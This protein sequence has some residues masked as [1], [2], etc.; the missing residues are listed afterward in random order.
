[1]RTS[2][3]S[4]I[5]CSLLLL[6]LLAG[7]AVNPVTGKRELSLFQ[8][9]DA[10]EVE[11]GKKSFPSA[12]QQMGGAYPEARL[13]S[14]VQAVGAKLAQYS[15][16]PALPWSFKVVNDSSPN[17]FAVP[18]GY[19]AISRGLLVNLE[20]EAQLAAVLGHEVAHVDARHSVQGMQRGALLDATLAIVSGVTGESAYGP[21]TR[22]ASEFAAGMLDRS[23]SREQERESDRIGIDYMVRAGYNPQGAVQLQ[24]FFYRKLEGGSDPSWVTG[25]FRTH[26]FS[27][28]RLE[29]NRAYIAS[30]YAG[31]AADPGARLNGS[32][33][34]GAIAELDKT[35]EGYDLYDEARRLEGQGNLSA[36]VA[37][38]LQAAAAAPDQALILT[39]LG[40]AYLKSGDVRSAR[41]H[42]AKAVQLDPNYYNSRL[43]LGYIYLQ[44]ENAQ[45]AVGQLEK[46]MTLLPTLQGAYLLAEGYEGVGRQNDAL[47]LYRQVAEADPRGKLGQAAARRINALEGR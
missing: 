4:H 45:E 24:E 47:A 38:Y 29:A 41:L 35:S 32:A 13:E 40:T 22:Q 7:C 17:A 6:L 30:R 8:V 2:Y 25:L 42:L 39:G 26:P 11:L 3:F 18:G 36:A 19:I 37:A 5:V 10:Q 21:L 44:Q 9:T 1:M 27:K 33:L 34:K 16:R 31:V 46:S 43:G 15:S 28:E 23:Y 20:N 14:Y 12:L